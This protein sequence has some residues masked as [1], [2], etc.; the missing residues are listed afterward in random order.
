MSLQPNRA[1]AVAGETP[2]VRCARQKHIEEALA[3]FELAMA[4]TAQATLDEVS[5]T[6][7][8]LFH[9]GDPPEDLDFSLRNFTAPNPICD[10]NAFYAKTA[11]GEGRAI[12]SPVPPSTTKVVRKERAEGKA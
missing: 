6:V 10:P 7:A 4:Q 12:P 11:V 1:P 5:P 8:P 3:L 2:H 9:A